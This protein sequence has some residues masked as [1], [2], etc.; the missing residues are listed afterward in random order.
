MSIKE[1]FYK[2]IN[3]SE[4][5]ISVDKLVVG[6]WYKVTDKLA[7]MKG[8]KKGFN[9]KVENVTSRVNAIKQKEY[10][11]YFTY[12]RTG[13]TGLRIEALSAFDKFFIPIDSLDEDINE[14]STQDAKKTLDAI[15][16]FLDDKDKLTDKEEEIRD[17]GIGMMDYYE[18]EKSFSPD[19][20][21]WIYNTSK[22]FFESYK[23]DYSKRIINE[24]E[25]IVSGLSKSL[26]ESEK[27]CINQLSILKKTNKDSEK[28]IKFF[29]HFL[30]EITDLINDVHIKNI[31]YK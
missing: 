28:Y 2:N 16:G 20:A 3:E 5:P 14:N 12:K 19:Q 21:K 8:F 1:Y 10:T 6:N 24:G 7:A 15:L 11:V 26:K 30:N 18:K 17:M 4:S 27:Y 29:E 9:I 23:E 22:A 31:M 25:D 13:Q